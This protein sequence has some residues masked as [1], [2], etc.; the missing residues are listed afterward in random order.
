MDD[1][2]PKEGEL[3]DISKKRSGST[4]SGASSAIV[5]ENTSTKFP[6]GLVGVLFVLA[7]IAFLTQGG[8]GTKAKPEKIAAYKQSYQSV[9]ETMKSQLPNL[10]SIACEGSNP[11]KEDCVNFVGTFRPNKDSS[12]YQM[13]MDTTDKV[14]GVT[15]ADIEL[16]RS[17]VKVLAD[18]KRIT[19]ASR[20]LFTFRIDSITIP[21]VGQEYTVTTKCTE[22]GADDV[23]CATVTK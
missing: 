6:L 23:V 14:P 8:G 13:T 1:D 12:T 5:T 2:L 19:I 15:P 16:I 18:A 3:L 20:E 21:K 9:F 22:S 17:N 11:N 4:S 10:V 7:A